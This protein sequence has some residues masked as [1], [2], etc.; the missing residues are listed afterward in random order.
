MEALFSVRSRHQ[1]PMGAAMRQIRQLFYRTRQARFEGHLR[2]LGNDVLG[3]C[4]IS[5]E[6]G[7]KP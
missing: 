3:R 4:T 6:R 1:T 5:R 2:R 7:F